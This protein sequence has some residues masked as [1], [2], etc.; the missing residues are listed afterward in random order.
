MNP[1]PRLSSNVNITCCESLH[2]GDETQ[3]Y[4]MSVKQIS[5]V[6]KVLNNKMH[7]IPGC[8]VIIYSIV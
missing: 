8:K 2:T 1:A 6:H 7:Y 3:M 5:I 4:G